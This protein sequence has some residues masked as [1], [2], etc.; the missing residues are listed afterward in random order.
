ME[1]ENTGSGDSSDVT[2]LG[3]NKRRSRACNEEEVEAIN[4]MDKMNS[5]S[6]GKKRSE[7]YWIG[8]LDVL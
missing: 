6:K 1:Q 8:L 7:K 2:D 3:I 5:R 4:Q